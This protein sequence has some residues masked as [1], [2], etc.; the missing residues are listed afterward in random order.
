MRRCSSICL[1]VGCPGSRCKFDSLDF[2]IEL[3]LNLRLLVRLDVL[4]SWSHQRLDLPLVLGRGVVAASFARSY[5]FSPG[6]RQ[7]V[8]YAS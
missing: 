5:R 3:L 7:H 4:L 8:A 2:R 6:G 1:S